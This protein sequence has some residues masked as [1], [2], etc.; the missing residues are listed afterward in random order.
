MSTGEERRLTDNPG[1][2]INAAWSPDGSRLLFESD[3]DGF[4]QIYELNLG[5]MELQR[6]SDGTGDDHGPQW[7]PDG[8]KIVFRSFRDGDNSVLYRMNAD[9]SNV[10]RLSDPAG[11]A[12]NAAISPDS[13]L[14]AYQSNLDGDNDVYVYDLVTGQTRLITDNN[15]EDYAPTW[16]CSSTTIV[17]TSD[18]TGDSNLF[19]TQALPLDAKPILVETQA[20]QLTAHPQSDQFPESAPPD[21]SASSQGSFP[22]PAKNK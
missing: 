11:F 9:G 20:N 16:W 3:R 4:W 22:S 5:T 21:E 13:T 14:V 18:V 8:K 17:F 7:S 15:I 12:M 2:D 10:T 19:D 1:N 6:L